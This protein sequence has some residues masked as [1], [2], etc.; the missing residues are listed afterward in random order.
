M[1]LS[2]ITSCNFFSGLPT[3]K[4]MCTSSK[5]TLISARF[6]WLFP[7]NYTLYGPNHD[8]CII[9]E[10]GFVIEY[11]DA[12]GMTEEDVIVSKEIIRH[13]MNFAKTGYWCLNT[14]HAFIF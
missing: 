6:F 8:E 3:T 2:I 13:Q 10:F 1:L 12:L 7:H 9:Y 4:A 14:V 5:P 11:A